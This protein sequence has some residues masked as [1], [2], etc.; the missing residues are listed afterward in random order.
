MLQSNTYSEAVRED[1]AQA[2][3]F[4]IAEVPFFVFNR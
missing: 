1:I 4:E 3:R 2:Q